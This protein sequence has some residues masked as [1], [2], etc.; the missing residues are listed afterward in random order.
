MYKRMKL[1]YLINELLPKIDAIKNYKAFVISTNPEKDDDYLEL[2][3]K[4]VVLDEDGDEI[5]IILHDDA[6]EIEQNHEILTV[7]Q[8]L[9][10]L[11]AFM[12]KAA[13]FHIFVSHTVI[14]LDE[15]YST[16]LDVPI[17]GHGFSEESFSFGL[18]ENEPK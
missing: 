7:D 1:S 6:D 10:K 16:R 3:I 17:I 2:P 5:N 15:E 14:D 9:V 8:L 18:F 11:E 12:P 13:T 4:D